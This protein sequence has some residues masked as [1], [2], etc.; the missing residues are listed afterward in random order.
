VQGHALIDRHFYLGE[1]WVGDDE[2]REPAGVPDE[3]AFTTKPQ[4]VGDM[5]QAAHASGIR[6]AWVAADELY[7]G[8]E[9]LC[10]I[11]ILGHGYAIA[12]P[13]SH[14]VTTQG[15]KA[16]VTTLLE[17]VPKGPMNHGK[18]MIEVHLGRRGLHRG[19]SSSPT[20]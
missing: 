4:L 8:E 19:R 17:R 2:R 11:R 6:S 1:A 9:L 16:K 7:G 5:L 10:R 14:R 12:V 3:T 15:G 18:P 20:E 13:A